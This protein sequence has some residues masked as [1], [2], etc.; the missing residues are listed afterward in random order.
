MCAIALVRLVAFCRYDRSIRCADIDRSGFVCDCPDDLPIEVNKLWWSQWFA[1]ACNRSSSCQ[2]CGTGDGRRCGNVGNLLLR[3]ND[4]LRE[5]LFERYDAVPGFC[6][7]IV[8]ECEGRCILA[9]GTSIGLRDGHLRDC[10]CLPKKYPA[11]DCHDG[12]CPKKCTECRTAFLL[13]HGFFL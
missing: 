3:Y 5:L 12:N 8:R 6:E 7:A 10:I 9:D 11:C 2:G 13:F 4:G 1:C